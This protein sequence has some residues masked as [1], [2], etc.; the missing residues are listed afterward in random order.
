MFRCF[1]LIALACV[2]SCLGGTLRAQ[3][4]T[5]RSDDKKSSNES[6]VVSKIVTPIE[7]DR[8]ITQWIILD[9]QGIVDCS[10]E[11]MDRSS[12]E[13][14]KQFAKAMINEHKDCIS[15]LEQ[16]GSR[17]DPA[18]RSE[19]NAPVAR[20]EEAKVNPARSG[21]LTKDQNGELRDRKWVYR[22]TDFVEVKKDIC[23]RMKALMMK[24]MKS[25]PAAEFDAMYMKHMVFG[26]EAI[27]ASCQATRSTASAEL[28]AHLDQNIEK[29][30]A[31]LKQARELCKQVSTS[32]TAKR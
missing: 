8:R 7:N 19:K 23:D 26:H 18:T 4:T 6:A 27:L 32:T 10:K 25:L 9:V 24:E 22:P 31:H 20:I 28:Q 1:Q 14:V 29:L 2:C 3:E 5:T 16:L 13:S 21:V 11:A 12:N 15:K 17:E 30:N